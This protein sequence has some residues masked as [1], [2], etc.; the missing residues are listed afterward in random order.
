MLA[1]K[2]KPVSAISSK[3]ATSPGNS[4]GS[5]LPGFRK[6][7]RR[8]RIIPAAETHL[9]SSRRGT[10]S[11]ATIPSCCTAMELARGICCSSAPA[12]GASGNRRS[13]PEEAPLVCCSSNQRRRAGC[14]DS[15]LVSRRR[16]SRCC[17]SLGRLVVREGGGRTRI[18]ACQ[19]ASSR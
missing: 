2:S 3:A 1:G 4:V 14:W 15:P 7:A 5:C 16:R 11:A 10:V 6:P 9:G 12:I 19:R 13:S 17:F 18:R 8:R